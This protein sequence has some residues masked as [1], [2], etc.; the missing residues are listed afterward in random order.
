M[1]SKELPVS[2]PSEP[3]LFWGC[4]LRECVFK[5]YRSSEFEKLRLTYRSLIRSHP[6]VFVMVISMM[7]LC[8]LEFKNV[9]VVPTSH[10]GPR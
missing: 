4:F 6:A 5:T 9:G 7:E 2:V 3:Y 8:P 10:V 1:L